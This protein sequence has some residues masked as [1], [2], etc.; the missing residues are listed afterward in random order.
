MLD[1]SM[2]ERMEMSEMIL[3]AVENETIRIERDMTLSQE[4]IVWGIISL[5]RGQV[6]SGVLGSVMDTKAG[7]LLSRFLSF[8]LDKDRNYFVT[9][10]TG[11]QSLLGFSNAFG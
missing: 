5:V 9:N 11:L 8:E 3:L 4:E 2:Q 6:E 7:A 10:Q 1:A